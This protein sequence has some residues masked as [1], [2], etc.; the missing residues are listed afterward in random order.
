MSRRPSEPTAEDDW[1]HGERDIPSHDTRPGFQ[2]FTSDVSSAL[3]DLDAFDALLAGKVELDERADILPFFAEHPRLALCFGFYNPLMARY[4]RLAYELSLFGLF[5]PDVIVGNWQRKSYCFVELEDA[6]PGSIFRAT[7]R[8]ATDWAPRFQRGYCQVVDW[9]WLL[10][11]QQDTPTF[12]AQFGKRAVQASGLLVIGRDQ[13]IDDADQQRFEWWRD[14]V[15]VDS[16]TIVCLTYDQ[17]ARDFR[18]RLMVAK[19]TTRP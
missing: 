10:E 14:R 16:R 13:F 11:A 8:R 17:L 9:F 15:V 19:A 18:D 12:E 3:D 7:T 6:K 1:K 4:D 2:A 5:R